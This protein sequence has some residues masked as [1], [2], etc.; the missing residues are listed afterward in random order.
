MMYCCGLGDAKTHAVITASVSG[1]LLTAAAIDPE[2]ISKALLGIAAG[3]TSLF[4]SVFSGCGQ[5]CVAA[6]QIADQVEQLLK[7]NRD[8]YLGMAPPRPRSLQ[9]QALNN[10][11]SAYAQL[12]SG[13][14]N[15]ALGDAGRR[16]ISDRQRG[17]RFPWPEWYRDPI[18]NDSQV[19]DDSTLAA[20][21][22][23]LTAG[24]QQLGMPGWLLPAALIALAIA[25]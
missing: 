2:P 8:T 6:T 12:I 10:F 17:G 9:V 15:P 19:Y 25:V 5:T 14:S 16:C 3:L 4:S 11:D 20:G 7:Q 24:A 1:G 22:G 18:A 23:V 13:C 21:A